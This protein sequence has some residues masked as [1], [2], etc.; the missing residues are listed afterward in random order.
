MSRNRSAS[1]RDVANM[2]GV[3]IATASRVLTAS[4]HPV[5]AGVRERVASAA[6]S[7]D[8][9]PDAMARS[10]KSNRSGL[11]GVVVPDITASYGSAVVRGV[12]AVAAESGHLVLVA[13]GDGEPLAELAQIR[14]LRGAR[15]DGII[16]AGLGWREPGYLAELAAHA[17]ALRDRGH[18]LV[19]VGQQIAGL[20]CVRAAEEAVS[21]L[22]AGYLVGRGHRAIAV[23]AGPPSSEAAG[24]F[25]HGYREALAVGGVEY[26]AT[27]VEHCE[28]TR[29]GGASAMS[30]LLRHG[31]FFT[32]V[33][34]SADEVAAGAL[35]ALRGEG[36]R[37][38]EEISVV[39]AGDTP[40]AA[41]ACPALTTVAV[42]VQEL[43]QRAM[44][45]VLHL[46]DPAL[47]EEAR[48]RLDRLDDVLTISLVERASVRSLA[49]LARRPHR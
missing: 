27:L 4:N 11:V 45:T 18:A 32:A 41:Y 15:A 39:G 3:S 37:V 13:A 12:Q 28:R 10:L 6:K 14:A 25:V 5:S 33:C 21:R 1:L 7:L 20:P 48:G 8:Y 43:G 44:R 30:S 9:Y 49:G 40:E 23:L 42:P 34:A 47:T 46:L 26:E 16:V 19:V 24:Q 35:A 38:P 22:A 36:V 2:A 29:E 17:G 31:A